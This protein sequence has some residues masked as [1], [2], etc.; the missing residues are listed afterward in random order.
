MNKKYFFFDVDGTLTD[1]KTGKIVPSAQQ[2]LNELEQNGHFV[3][4]A[5][6][7]A[8]YKA[9]W[10]LDE[11]KLKNMVCCGGAGLVVDG[12]LVQNLPIDLKKAKKLVAEAKA[13]GIGYLLTL[14]DSTD[15]FSDNNLF[16]EQTGG[17]KEPTNYIIN[18]NLDPSKLD[19][20]YKV[21]LSVSEEDEH[22]LPTLQEFGFLR[23]EPEYLIIQHDRKKQGIIEMIEKVGGNLE[24][25][26]V[27]GDDKNDL[28]MFDPR[29]FSVAMGNG[30]QELKDKANYV[31]E[32]NID[33]GIYKTCKK[34]GWI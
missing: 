27:F 19:I 2:A 21:Y 15:C 31:A 25:V 16:V 5:T 33:D 17:R 4:L 7:R 12:E 8:H 14:N 28:D 34:F 10:A 22:L 18:E 13:N 20:I 1:R 23:F 6:G 32:T 9:R 3:A 30:M 24:D 29:W 26:V 11:Y